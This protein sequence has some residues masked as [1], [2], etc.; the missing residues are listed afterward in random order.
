MLSLLVLN[1]ISH[2][3][4]QLC[5]FATISP[6]LSLYYWLNFFSI[7]V[8]NKIQL[9]FLFHTKIK[10]VCILN[11][12]IASFGSFLRIFYNRAENLL[13]TVV[14]FFWIFLKFYRFFF[15]QS[16]HYRR[17]TLIFTRFIFRCVLFIFFFTFC[18]LYDCLRYKSIV[19]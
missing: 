2:D 18:L 7:F 8:N 5:H 14:G 6:F 13:T 12:N 11:Q 17:L 3:I 4:F 19:V 15:F 9:I 16:S 1:I 10:I